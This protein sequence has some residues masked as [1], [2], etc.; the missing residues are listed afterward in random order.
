MAQGR[1]RDPDVDARI[2][3]ATRALLGEETWEEAYRTF[4][5]EWVERGLLARMHRYTIKS[6]RKEIQA[7]SAA[8]YMRFLFQWHGMGEIRPE[9][10]EALFNAIDRIAQL[11]EQPKVDVI[12][13]SKGVLSVDLYAADVEGAWAAGLPAVLVDPF[14]D[15]PA[16]ECPKLP[17]LGALADRLL[18]G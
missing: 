12:A 6:L 1:P 13:W 11:T 10:S 5:S 7:V 3:Q 4:I 14:D 8:D 15:W 9:G 18:A 16:M 17:D 2:V